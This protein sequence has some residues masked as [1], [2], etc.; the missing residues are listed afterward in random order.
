[1]QIPEL[2]NEARSQL[3]KPTAALTAGNDIGNARHSRR[4]SRSKKERRGKFKG[5][6]KT[7]NVRRSRSF[8]F[9][10]GQENMDPGLGTM[11]RTGSGFST[12]KK[13]KTRKQRRGRT[14]DTFKDGQ[15]CR[16]IRESDRIPRQA[17][18]LPS[19]IKRHIPQLEDFHF[20][21]G[22]V[23]ASGLEKKKQTQQQA[24][25]GNRTV[26]EGFWEKERGMGERSPLPPSVTTC[27]ES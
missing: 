2:R 6:R 15:P 17:G 25:R 23:K 10:L 8:G 14:T 22:D 20:L 5:N 27:T 26:S 21:V 7:P 9:G 19:V 16:V 12:G 3:P 1:M 4:R 11:P 18:I 24:Q 13:N